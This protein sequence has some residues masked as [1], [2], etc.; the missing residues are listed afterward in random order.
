MLSAVA[1]VAITRNRACPMCLVNA[2]STA[3]GRIIFVNAKNSTPPARFTKPGIEVA[4][5]AAP[6]CS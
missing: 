5:V 6:I 4:G 1:V 3:V 2:W